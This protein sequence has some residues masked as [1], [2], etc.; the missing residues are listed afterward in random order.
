MGEASVGR[1]VSSDILVVD[2]EIFEALGAVR[3]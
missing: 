1:K 2:F 3:M